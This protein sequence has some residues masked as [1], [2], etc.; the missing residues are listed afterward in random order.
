MMTTMATL[1][2]HR[3]SYARGNYD[4]FSDGLPSTYFI[5]AE[6]MAYCWAEEAGE[7]LTR[8]SNRTLVKAALKKYLNSTDGYGIAVASAQIDSSMPFWELVD[9]ELTRSVFT[10]DPVAVYRGLTD[11]W[12]D[13]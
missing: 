9:P 11:N 5:Q 8:C 2:L 4:D 10:L 3:G 7:D 1:R 12:M 13:P 6:M